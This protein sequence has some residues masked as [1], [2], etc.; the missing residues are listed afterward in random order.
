MLLHL[1]HEP[2]RLFYAQ[3]FF[4]LPF[5]LLSSFLLAFFTPFFSLFICV[6]LPN[7]L[8]V[9]LCMFFFRQNFSLFTFIVFT[10]S[11]SPHICFALQHFMGVHFVCC[12]LALFYI[13][14]NL[15]ITLSFAYFATEANSKSKRFIFLSHSPITPSNLFNIL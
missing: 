3:D 12:F 9:C 2:T 7:C 6:H 5:F 13:I 1:D 10:S 11:F 8:C 15:H 4:F 14:M